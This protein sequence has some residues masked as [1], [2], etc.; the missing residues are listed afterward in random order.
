MQEIDYTGGVSGLRGFDPEGEAVRDIVLF[1]FGRNKIE[2]IDPAAMQSVK[3]ENFT[4]PA[5]D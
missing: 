3:L 2:R 4:L 1:K 5:F